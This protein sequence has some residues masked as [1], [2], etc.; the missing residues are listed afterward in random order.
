MQLSYTK[1]I[2]FQKHIFDWWKLRKRDLP[3]RKTRNPYRIMVAEVMLQQTQVS[4]V[5]PVYDN[6][7]RVFPDVHAL[8]AAPLADVLR[9][10]KG[11]GYNRRALYLHKTASKIVNL[12]KGIFPKTE[13][14]LIKLPGLGKYTARAILVFAYEQNVSMVDTNIRRIITR[15][16]YND[17]SQKES[18]IQKTADTLI[19]KGR[20]WEWHQALMDYGAIEMSKKK[21][22]KATQEASKMSKKSV[23]FRESKRFYRGKILD[24]LRECST[25]QVPLVNDL[26]EKYG[27]D[28]AFYQQ[29]ISELVRDG[30]IMKT[31]IDTLDL[32]I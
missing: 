18:E 24:I 9:A 15:F 27:G 30:L 2:D 5:L 23:P 22:V 28:A 19:P 11:M 7:L 26:M 13:K 1:V 17:V 4:R 20:S 8:A 25:P 12:H 32:P 14:E 3:W 21:A 10:W 6:F 31:S 29:I 16:F